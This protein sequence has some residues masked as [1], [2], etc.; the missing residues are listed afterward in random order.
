[1]KEPYW[2]IR[3]QIFK[4]ERLL[5]QHK[6]TFESDGAIQQMLLMLK[7]NNQHLQELHR[8]AGL[9][10]ICAH[11]A[12]IEDQCCCGTGFELDYTYPLLLIN[13]LLGVMIPQIPVYEDCCFFLGPQGCRLQIRQHICDR[14]LCF[15][16]KKMLTQQE[17]SIIYRAAENKTS[18]VINLEE[19]IHLLVKENQSEARRRAQ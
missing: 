8:E 17:V 14:Y 2:W 1:M 10:E 9:N 7:E 16:M 3:R 18:I 4:A 12:L 6:L 13:L 11:C 19:H 15:K 5:D